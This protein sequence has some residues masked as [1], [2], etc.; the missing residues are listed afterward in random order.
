[1]EFINDIAQVA[2]ALRVC[3]QFSYFVF[4]WFN[5]FLF[6]FARVIDGK[7]PGHLWEPLGTDR[8][9]VCNKN[10]L[11]FLNRDA[12]SSGNGMA[13]SVF[14]LRVIRRLLVCVEAI[15]LQV[16]RKKNL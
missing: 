1:M 5:T 8:P 12:V 11:S 10:I 7:T 16:Y 3:M 4:R 13:I 6:P 2:N 9:R 14:R 15:A